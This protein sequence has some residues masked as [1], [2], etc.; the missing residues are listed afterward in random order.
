MEQDA[1]SSEGFYDALEKI[2]AELRSTVS[3]ECHLIVSQCVH[4]RSVLQEHA[5]PLLKPVRRNE[6]PGYDIGA[7]ELGLYSKEFVSEFL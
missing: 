1:K 7:Q 2:L 6:A 3:D 4:K 5:H